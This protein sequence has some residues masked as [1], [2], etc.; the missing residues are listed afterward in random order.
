[1]A[2]L[3]AKMDPKQF[4]QA[5][6]GLNRII[7]FATIEKDRLPMRQ[8]V[9]YVNLLRANLVS[10]KFV[11]PPYSEDYAAWKAKQPWAMKGNW[12]LKGDLL[13]SLT[14]FKPS[15]G[16]GWRGGIPADAMDSGGKNWSGKGPPKSIAMYARTLEYALAGQKKRAVF[17]P[18]LQEY[19]VGG[20]VREMNQTAME[21]IKRWGG[22]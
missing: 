3:F 18:T 7:R 15:V 11:H 5:M 17:I 14:A 2:K 19:R 6:S 10:N 4:S 1:M 9:G 13:K 16:D 21:L 8:A 12:K 20:A 22:R